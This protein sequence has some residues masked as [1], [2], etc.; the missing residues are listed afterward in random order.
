M[1]HHVIA[2]VPPIGLDIDGKV[3]VYKR[4]YGLGSSDIA[5][6]RPL[7]V[8]EW[9]HPTLQATITETNEATTHY[10]EIYTDGSKDVSMDGAG[11]V[12]YRN[13][14]MIIQYRCKLRSYCSNHQAE[15]IA[16]LKALGIQE[17]ET[18]IGGRRQ[19][20]LTAG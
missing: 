9:P 16:I 3:Q 11:V 6:D 17:I 5:C 18:P 15:Q 13:K 19:Y 7:P 10:I 1:R 12:I 2:A 4:K 14:Q 8:H 20:T